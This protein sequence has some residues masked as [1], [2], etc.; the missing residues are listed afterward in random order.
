L[1]P[2]GLFVT[3]DRKRALSR[4]NVGFMTIDHP[5][6]RGAIDYLL[7]S[8]TGN[9]G[10]GIWKDS[11]GEGILLDT[12]YVIECIAPAKLHVDRFLPM[13]PVRAVATHAL[14]DMT[15]HEGFT[16]TAL[17]KGDASKLLNNGGLRKKFLPAMLKSCSEFAK[18]RVQGLMDAATM[19]VETALDGEIERLRDLAQRNDHVSEDDIT[20]LE[21]EK[22][23]LLAAIG[24]A[25]HRLDGLRLVMRTQ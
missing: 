24:T 11:K 23:E 2:E 13:V 6:V 19:A 16:G 22:A 4:E 3:F 21:T 17:L 9:T 20:A 12:N 1:P 25:T 18:D 14:Q 15:T 8:E 5:L 10:F 7:A